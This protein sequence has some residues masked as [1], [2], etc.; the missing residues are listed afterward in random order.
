[1]GDAREGRSDDGRDPE[2]AD[3]HGRVEDQPESAEEFRR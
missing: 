1:V 2:E 3:R